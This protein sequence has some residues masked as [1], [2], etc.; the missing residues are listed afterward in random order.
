MNIDNF[1]ILLIENDPKDDFII[2]D[3]LKKN[4]KL[5]SKIAGVDRLSKALDL[6]H[7]ENFD[8]ILT[9]LD[10]P[11]SSGLN[12]VNKLLE[13]IDI[14]PIIVLTGL[15]DENIGNE[16]VKHGAQDYLVKGDVECTVL[17]RAMQYAI[18][19]KKMEIQLKRYTE[20]LEYEV[21]QRANELI[22]TEKMASLGQMVAGVAHEVN[23]PLA[24]INS[25]TTYIE[26]TIDI[27]K[28][29]SE[30][31]VFK[32]HLDK[33]R[34]LNKTNMKGIQRIANITKALL[35]FA[36]PNA[37]NHV[38]ADINQGIQDTL[39][40]L[41]YQLKHRIS[42][43]ENYGDIPKIE[44]NI[45]QLNQVFMNLIINSSQAMDEG[46]IWIKTFRDDNNIYIEIKDNGSGITKDIIKKIFDPFFTTKHSGTGLGLSLCYRIINDHKGDIKV[47]SKPGKGTEMLIRIPINV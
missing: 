13:T 27:L 8:I 3:M 20:H 44:C 10:L 43:H 29:Y 15:D 42:I 24:F 17:T 36:M 41:Y 31:K 23:N 18:H 19:Q 37:D 16:A 33:L 26:N 25:N 34:I 12:T 6:L 35:R 38:I 40:I 28:R 5:K 46:D 30:D 14:T 2:K 47:K 1:K 45:S 9:D 21:E 4:K 22:Q 7:N 11:D 39:M 32:E